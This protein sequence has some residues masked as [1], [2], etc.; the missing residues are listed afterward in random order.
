MKIDN[1]VSFG[2]K[3]INHINV[4]KLN[5]KNYSQVEVPFVEIN[6]LNKNDID[7]LNDI[8][9]Y[10]IDDK[11]ATNISVTANA[12]Y[13]DKNPEKIKIYALT[14]QTDC[15]EKLN[16]DNIL[17]V[18]ETENISPFHIHINRFQVK[19]DYVYNRDLEYAG[20]GTSILS[21]LKA[22]CNK[23][24]AISECD[25]STKMF[26]VRNGFQEHPEGSNA[27]TWYKDIFEDVFENIFKQ[28]K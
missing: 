12:I 3:Y 16:P 18:I 11:F 25:E 27:F 13:E 19:P 8:A 1:K 28:Y 22:L 20:V 21:S 9:K 4:G 14:S 7:A 10:W 24:T 26:Y 2:A 23:I 17:G 15:F 5:G 6:P